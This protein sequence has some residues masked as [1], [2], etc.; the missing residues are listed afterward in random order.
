VAVLAH[1]HNRKVFGKLRA[2]A[3]PIVLPP[4][5][6]D[7]E[8]HLIALAGGAAQAASP[9]GD[10]GVGA[11]SRDLIGHIGF[12]PVPA[13]LAPYDQPDLGRERLAQR[14]R[15]RLALASIAPH[16]PTMTPEL[17]DDDKAILAALLREMIARDRFPLSPR[18]RSYK[19]ILDKLAPP[20]PRPEP[21][22]APKPPGERSM[23]L[24]AKKRRR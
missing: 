5:P 6:A 14:H 15:H 18:V 2:S 8:I 10:G 24:T 17:S 7:D 23:A 1:H 12:G 9:I 19:T 13:A 3:A 11:I 22:P 20:A 16:N 4:R 21:I